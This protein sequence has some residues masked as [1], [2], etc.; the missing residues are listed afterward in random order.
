MSEYV[1]LDFVRS[2][3]KTVLAKYGEDHRNK[4][5]RWGNESGGELTGCV[6]VIAIKNG[7][8]YE[9]SP[10]LLGGDSFV[11][12]GQMTMENLEKAGFELAPGC[13]VGT[14]LIES[15]LI[16]IKQFVEGPN[17]DMSVCTVANGAPVVLRTHGI[18]TSRAADKWLASAQSKQ[19]A[20]ATWGEAAQQADTYILDELMFGSIKLSL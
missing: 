8:R 15:G 18:A 4:V 2:A 7:V 3:A 14:I 1:D 6:N 11:T 20:G 17:E 10:E 19:D 16:S 5:S 9:I 12:H 13:L